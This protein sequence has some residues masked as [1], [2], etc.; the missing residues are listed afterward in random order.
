[1]ARAMSK[2]AKI[3]M[4]GTY[5]ILKPKHGGQKRASAIYSMY[6]KSGLSVRYA[7]VIPGKYYLDRTKSDVPVSIDTMKAIEETPFL[8]DIICGEAIFS[9]PKARSHMKHVIERFRPTIIHIE[10]AYPYLGLKKL[11]VAMNYK[12][13]I[14][15]STQNLE[16]SMKNQMYKSEGM[17]TRLRAKIVTRI[18]QLEQDLANDAVVNVAVSKGEVRSLET[19]FGAKNV[20]LAPNG[21]NRQT[22]KRRDV[23]KWQSSFK[24]DSIKFKILFVGSAHTPNMIGF[25]QMV[26]KRIGFLP[27][28]TRILVVG[29]VADLLRRNLNE[30][31]I[32]DVC[33]TQRASL[34][35][36]VS[37]TDLAALLYLSD[38][39]ILPITGGGGSNLKTAEALLAH[40]KIVATSHAFRGYEEYTQYPNILIADSSDQFRRSIKEQL[41]AHQQ[42]YSCDQLEKIDKVLWENAL[43]PLV[44]KVKTI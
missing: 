38:L 17:D 12:A 34:L 27:F 4:V 41:T 20:V 23:K 18:K 13:K 5:P 7:S 1:M 31:A 43:K 15:N 33:F 40:K 28:G 2:S 25:L 30:T 19:Q 3:L 32:E 36:H 42:E 35:G 24:R 9:D 8:N 21:M 37:E 14:I 26:S 11:L 6:K 29:G 22:P 16:W 39:I 44:E 10:Q